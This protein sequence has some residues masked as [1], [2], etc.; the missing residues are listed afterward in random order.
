MLTCVPNL[1][2]LHWCLS[3]LST[4]FRWESAIIVWLRTRLHCRI[5]NVCLVLFDLYE[6]NLQW[7]QIR[8]IIPTT[9]IH[10]KSQQI[11]TP[12][13]IYG[14]LF[15]G[16]SKNQTIETR[17]LRFSWYINQHLNLKYCKAPCSVLSVSWIN[18]GWKRSGRILK[19][20]LGTSWAAHS[21]Q[22]VGN[23]G[24]NPRFRMR[25]NFE[26]LNYMLFCIM[27]LFQFLKILKTV[28]SRIRTR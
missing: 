25:W 6:G 21:G 12:Q 1:C 16:R 2:T 19:M 4:L 22:P 14:K 11:Y 5:R 20:A 26:G 28:L 15:R 18:H 13:K 7:T 9:I 3:Q 23:S 8:V 24:K 27:I 17:D 10:D